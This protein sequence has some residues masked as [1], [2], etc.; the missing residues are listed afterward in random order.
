VRSRGSSPGA[1]SAAGGGIRG[2]RRAYPPLR[3][4]LRLGGPRGLHRGGRSSD[5]LLRRLGM[6]HPAQQN[7]AQQ[8]GAERTQQAGQPALV[9]EYHPDFVSGSRVD[10]DTH[11]KHCNLHP[12]SGVGDARRPV[13][14]SPS[15]NRAESHASTPALPR[16][17]FEAF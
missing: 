4:P 2:R 3:L 5:A 1:T 12:F 6:D 9:R 13:D 14:T 15:S 11:V 16:A 8:R 17:S 7:A 10:L